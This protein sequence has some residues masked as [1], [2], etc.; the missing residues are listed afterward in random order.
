V[1]RVAYIHDVVHH[2]STIS[3]R[4]AED[5]QVKVRG[6]GMLRATAARKAGGKEVVWQIDRWRKAAVRSAQHR[7]KPSVVCAT[8]DSAAAQ[9]ASAR[10]L[11][12]I[13]LFVIFF[14]FLSCAPP[15]PVARYT[16]SCHRRRYNANDQRS[17]RTSY[18]LFHVLH[19]RSASSD[20]ATIILMSTVHAYRVMPAAQTSACVLFPQNR[21]RLSAARACVQRTNSSAV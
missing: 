3:A 7:R 4:G 9:R 10:F 13:S 5:V 6:R 18:H 17:S 15:F 14:H 12:T 19:R 21:A 20:A 16:A 8:R 1:L 2:C 11:F